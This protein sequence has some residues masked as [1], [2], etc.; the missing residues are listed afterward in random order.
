MT[1]SSTSGLPPSFPGFLHL[2]FPPSDLQ[3]IS[4]P[5]RVSQVVETLNYSDPE[6]SDPRVVTSSHPKPSD[7]RVGTSRDPKPSDPRVVTSAQVTPKVVFSD[8]WLNESREAFQAFI[9]PVLKLKASQYCRLD[10][11]NPSSETETVP[12]ASQNLKPSQFAHP[13][14]SLSDVAAISFPNSSSS[15]ICWRLSEILPASIQGNEIT[16]DSG[17]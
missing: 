2:H 4:N 8:F 15:P 3:I 11:L 14:D 10:G 9:R 7:P 17:K 16:C 13:A 6:P 5:P 12:L 1:P